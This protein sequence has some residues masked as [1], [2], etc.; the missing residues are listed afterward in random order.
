MPD[1]K[2]DLRYLRYALITAKHNSFRRTAAVLGIPQST[3]SRRIQ[4]LEHS[5]GFAIFARDNR[6]VTLTAAGEAFLERAATGVVHFDRAV[7]IAAS[8]HR[9][10]CGD[11]H[12]GIMASLTSGF[13]RQVL[14]QYR[15]KHAGVRISLHEGTAQE[16][17]HRL[18]MGT[19][20]VAFVT[21]D[22]V[23]PGYRTAILGRECV[24]V[25]LP[26]NH[27]LA[28]KHEVTWEEIRRENF[29]VST[30]GPGPEIQDYLIKRLA[31][32]GFSPKIET[33]E[34]SRESLMNLVAIGY[35]LTLTS[36]SSHGARIAGVI[37]RP[38]AGNADVLTSS[39]IWSANNSNTAV[40]RLLAVAK[41]V[42]R[43]FTSFNDE[44]TAMIAVLNILIPVGYLA[45]A[46]LDMFT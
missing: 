34:I 36:A 5:L 20:D 29:I 26:S 32:L 45:R 33:Q 31:S 3:V 13:L 25:V 28:I 23:L 38:I 19:L 16:S 18:A 30:G 21:G 15:V 24:F 42:A 46:P 17:F 6:G 44:H 8:T 7:L 43:D 40:K 11:L 41:A 4:L 35:G 12:I 22:L 1:L 14:R 10:E 39:A 27:P 37:L 9:G 2:L